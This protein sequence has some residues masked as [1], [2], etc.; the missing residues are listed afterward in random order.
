MSENSLK[1]SAKIEM[2]AERVYLFI[3]IGPRIMRTSFISNQRSC[4]CPV[5]ILVLLYLIKTSFLYNILDESVKILEH[6]T[7]I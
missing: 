3:S 1:R 7:D 5:L 6:P 4:W 2:G